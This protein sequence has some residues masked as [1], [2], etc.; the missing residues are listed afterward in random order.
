M[1]NNKIW[2]GSVNGTYENSS[3]PV[4][5]ATCWFKFRYIYLEN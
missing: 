2:W 3:N 4:T 5:G 1:D